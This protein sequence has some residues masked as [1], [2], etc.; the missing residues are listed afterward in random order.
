[1][2][3]KVYKYLA[4][5]AISLIKS[6]SKEPA[7]EETIKK[8]VQKYDVKFPIFGKIDVNGANRHELWKHL[9]NLYVIEGHLCTTGDHGI[10]KITTNFAKF[11]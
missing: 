2:D 3:H 8:F 10:D 5:L 6:L 7:V 9:C 11:L 4:F 1:M